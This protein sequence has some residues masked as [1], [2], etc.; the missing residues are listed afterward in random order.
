MDELIRQ[1]Q[2]FLT[3]HKKSEDSGWPEVTPTEV[4]TLQDIFIELLT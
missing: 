3:T 2:A 4:N 1:I